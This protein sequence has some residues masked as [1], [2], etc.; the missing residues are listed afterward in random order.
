MTKITSIIGEINIPL[1]GKWSFLVPSTLLSN[2]PKNGLKASINEYTAVP[3]APITTA[4][5][6]IIYSILEFNKLYAAVK[7]YSFE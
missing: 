7:K 5:T 4:I 2:V 3:R 6:I 1:L